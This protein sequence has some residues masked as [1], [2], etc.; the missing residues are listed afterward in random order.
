MLY[1]H[2]VLYVVQEFFIKCNVHSYIVFAFTCEVVCYNDCTENFLSH[3]PHRISMWRYNASCI[4]KLFGAHVLEQHVEFFTEV[5]ADF[6]NVFITTLVP[7]RML[8]VSYT[9]PVKLSANL[10]MW[11]TNIYFIG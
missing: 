9:I 1:I 5:L 4:W 7:Q 2:V 10:W 6:I 3:D 8:Q 11:D